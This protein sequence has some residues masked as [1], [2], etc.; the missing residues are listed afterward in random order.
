MSRAAQMASRVALAGCGLLALFLIASPEPVAAAPVDSADSKSRADA[1]ISIVNGRNTSINDWPWQV[2]LTFGRKVAPGTSTSR[3]FFCGGSVLA[4][5]LVITAG[6]C[7]ADFNR[8]QIRR[9]EIVSGRTSLNSSRGQVVSVSGLRMPLDS[10]GKRRYRPYRGAANWDVALLTLASPVSAE[11]IRLAGP[12]ELEAWSTG[13]IAWTTGWGVTSGFSN[14][15]PTR[16]KVARQVIMGTGLCRR[17]DGRAFQPATMTCLGGP[18]GNASACSGDSGG[19]LVV[20]TSDGYR[21][22]GVTSFGD[23]A[24]RGFIPSVDTRVSGNPIRNWIAATASNLFGADVVGSGGVAGPLR[25]WC[26]VPQVFGLRPAKARRLLEESG[27]RLGKVRTD[28]WGAGPRGRIIGYSRYP[29][30]LARTGFKLNV[31][32]AP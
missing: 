5:R 22:V 27:C 3:R 4:P 28:P 10:S 12:D 16:L 24:C 23:G 32:L 11:P 9:L 6:H 25:K 19:P 26:K 13:R 2:A 15:V 18:A 30:W 21:L 14:R 20:A 17:A 8:R 1:G 31:W 29:G 7:V